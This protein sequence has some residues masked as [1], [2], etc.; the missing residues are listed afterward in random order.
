MAPL[1]YGDSRGQHHN[2][3]GGHFKQVQA[4]FPYSSLTVGEAG[5]G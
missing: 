4:D 3:Q 1:L 2:R 5:E